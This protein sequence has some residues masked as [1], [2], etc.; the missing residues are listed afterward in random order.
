MRLPR[1]IFPTLR[2]HPVSQSTWKARDHPVE[3]QAH[4][5]QKRVWTWPPSDRTEKKDR[6][7][8]C[9]RSAQEVSAL[10][11][12]TQKKIPSSA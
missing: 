1:L 5:E 4:A 12:R 2:I 9:E 10:V 11:H 7:D 6:W 3:C 8:F